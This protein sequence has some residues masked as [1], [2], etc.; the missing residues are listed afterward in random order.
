M[1]IAFLKF[2]LSCDAFCVRALKL[3]IDCF[4]G[5]SFA[6]RL[7]GLVVCANLKQMIGEAA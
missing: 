5:V 2:K 6:R 7:M 1:E 3:W 4:C